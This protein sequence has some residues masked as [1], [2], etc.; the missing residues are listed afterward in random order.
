M[1][2][3]LFTIALL[4]LLFLPCLAQSRA[5]QDIKLEARLVWG[6]DNEKPNDPNLKQLDN[7]LKDKLKGIFKWKNYFEVNHYKLAISQEAPKTQIMSP[8]CSIE[9][10]NLGDSL[11]EVKLFGEGKMVLKKRQPIKPGQP[12]VLAGDEKNNNA[13]FVV[14]TPAN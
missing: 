2:T 10:Q 6:T 13:W 11:I 3:R 8:K 1:I 4:A 12:I 14:L 9:V 5:G 7:S